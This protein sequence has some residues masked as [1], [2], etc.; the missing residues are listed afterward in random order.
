MTKQIY[1]D[2]IQAEE[3]KSLFVSRLISRI[4]IIII[5][6]FINVSVSVSMNMIYLVLYSTSAGFLTSK[7]VIRAA[8]EDSGIGEKYYYWKGRGWLPRKEQLFLFEMI[9]LFVYIWFRI[10]L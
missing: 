8:P 6:V 1:V 10:L 4:T 2:A 7:S 3:V 5:R 9:L